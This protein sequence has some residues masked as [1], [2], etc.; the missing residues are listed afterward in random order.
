MDSTSKD[1]VKWFRNSAPYINTHRGKTFVLM[2]SGDAVEHANFA[3]IIH[4]I[5]LL[6]SLGVKLILVHGARPQIESR[7]QLRGITPHFHKDLRVTDAATLEC[8]K[9]AAGNLRAQIEALLTTGLANSPMYGAQIRVCSGNFVIAKPMGIH[10]GVDFCN[11]GEVRRVDSEAINRLLQAGAIVLLSP[12]GYS[13]TGEVF[14]LSFEDVATQTAVALKADKIIAFTESSGLLKDNELIRFAELREVRLLMSHCRDQQ[15][16]GVLQALVQSCEHGVKRTHLISYSEDGALLQ[17]LFTRD[18]AGTLITEDQY[19][20]I[21]TAQINDIGGILAIIEP[22]E[23]EGKLVKRSRELLETE[24]NQFTVIDRDGMVIACAAL[25][26]YP[27]QGSG[28]IACVATHADY[29]GADRGERLLAALETKAAGLGLS[30]VFILT[31]R[32]A[33]WFQEQGFVPAS[34]EELPPQKQALY[35]YQRNSK[36]FVKEL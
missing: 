6:N 13:P 36:V 9:D 11:T 8:V 1:Y 14:N 30:K 15:M 7:C 22:L 24:I 12:I 26:P 33:H 10:D 27:E 23:S 21:R 28:E 16:L 20:Q 17:E 34:L 35:N 18:G 2:F 32:T 25:C 19:E 31:T 4:D 29:R 3:N 5:A